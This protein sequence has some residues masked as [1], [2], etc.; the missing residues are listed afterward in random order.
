MVYPTGKTVV[1]T[2]T[3]DC[4]VESYKLKKLDF[5]KI[6]VEGYEYQVMKGGEKSIKKFKPI[7]MY[8]YSRTIDKLSNTNNSYKS[9]NLINR[10]GYSQYAII[11]EKV[12][13]RISSFKEDLPDTNI[14]CF[15]V[16]KVPLNFKNTPLI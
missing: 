14:I 6:D 2:S 4:E 3:I 7:I 12:I 11:G 10:L 15:P 16:G 5:I 9:F 8:E 13:W 1:K